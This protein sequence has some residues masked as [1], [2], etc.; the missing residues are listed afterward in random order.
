VIDF[1]WEMCYTDVIQQIKS[2]KD[3]VMS[4]NKN[5]TQKELVKLT[6]KLIK[7]ESTVSYHK[8]LERIID[9]CAAYFKGSGFFIKKRYFE[10][11][12]SLVVMTKR[13][14]RPKLLLAGHLDVVPAEKPDF[15]PRLRAGK[16]YG[17]GASDMKAAVAVLMLVMQDMQA[18]KDDK[19]VGLILTTDEE[20]KHYSSM[21]YLIDRVGHRGDIV[22]LPDGGH[23]F[24]LV[25][26]QKGVVK[27]TYSFKGKGAHGS[28][29]W[30]GDN[31]VERIFRAYQDLQHLFPIPK[32]D[33]DWRS[34]V[35]LT[36][37]SGGE[38]YNKVPA[39]CE[40]FFDFRYTEDKSLERW[41]KLLE[42]VANQHKIEFILRQYSSAFSVNP[43]HE[44]VQ[45]YLRI[46]QKIL[47]KKVAIVP[48]AG[49]SDARFF[50]KHNIPVIIT[51]PK[52]GN[53]HADDEW[54]DTNSLYKFYQIVYRFTE[55][56]G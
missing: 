4:R 52:G 15:K 5:K 17:R 34:T 10:K 39:R 56:V 12:P 38:A 43:D 19:S 9:F 37:I 25:R 49:A 54:V 7:F 13:T 11:N 44:L 40:A 16:L 8:E 3:G 42:K 2:E 29:P 18:H 48:E 20:T 45:K 50:S 32:D 53:S 23:N 51:S 24:N 33:Q 27:F 1:W 21:G 30:L 6:K 31:A 35:V 26:A 46:S 47:R 14:K 28:R 22:F 36:K 55:E 41:I